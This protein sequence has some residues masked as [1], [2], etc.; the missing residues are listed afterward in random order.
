MQKKWLLVALLVGVLIG[1]AG[2]VAYK[3][4]VIPTTGTVSTVNVSAT[5]LDG[6]PVTSLDWSVTDNNTAYVMDLINVTNI[7]NVPVTLSLE[8]RNLNAS[9]ISLT[10]TWNYTTG[11]VLA[12]D[13]WVLVE[14]EQTVTATG[15]YSYDTIIKGEQS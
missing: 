12:P 5:W 3:E 1:V 8:T 2:A 4:L 14:L 9:I 13:E 7:S 6:E 10:L 11:T 15:A